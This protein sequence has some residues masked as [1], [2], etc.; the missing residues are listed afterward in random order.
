MVPAGD[1]RFIDCVTYWPEARG[2]LLR[3]SALSR[4][5]SLSAKSWLNFYTA[6]RNFQTTCY[7]CKCASKLAKHISN[8]VVADSYNASNH[9]HLPS[10]SNKHLYHAVTLSLRIILASPIFQ[11]EPPLLSCYRFSGDRS[12]NTK[13]ETVSG[14]RKTNAL[15]NRT[16]R[17]DV[18]Q[19]PT[20]TAADRCPDRLTN[21]GNV[22][23]LFRL[24]LPDA[25][26]Q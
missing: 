21:F 24:G 25:A 9:H 15:T 7:T 20:T 8:Y 2:S 19:V 13:P 5:W 22:F 26:V 14:E 3:I 10:S 23:L 17:L 4:E 1:L 6:L 11:T 16:S 18:G 12:L